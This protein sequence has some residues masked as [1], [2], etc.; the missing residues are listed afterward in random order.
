[1]ITDV[2][3]AEGARAEVVAGG[4]V[5]KGGKVWSIQVK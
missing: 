2:V 5:V 1:M 3:E 4:L